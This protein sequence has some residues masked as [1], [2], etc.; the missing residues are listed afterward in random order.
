MTLSLTNQVP[1]TFLNIIVSCLLP[2]VVGLLQKDQG[3]VLYLVLDL[4]NPWNNLPVAFSTNMVQKLGFFVQ[5]P[6]QPF[7]IAGLWVSRPF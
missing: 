3:R 4:Y 6:K 2:T 1:N 7:L 5:Q